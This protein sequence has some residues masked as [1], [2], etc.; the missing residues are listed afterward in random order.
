M[1][2]P[3][4]PKPQALTLRTVTF[5]GNTADVRLNEFLT[6]S[7]TGIETCCPPLRPQPPKV[8]TRVGPDVSTVF[9]R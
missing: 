2:R 3:Y 5:R 8:G 9:P 1:P 4:W 6:C 7:V